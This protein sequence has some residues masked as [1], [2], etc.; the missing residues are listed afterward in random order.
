M[1]NWLLRT[2]KQWPTVRWAR[3][4]N[5]QVSGAILIVG[6]ALWRGIFSDGLCHLPIAVKATNFEDRTWCFEFWFNRYQ[7]LLGGIA[8]LFAAFLAYKAVQRQIRSGLVSELKRDLSVL[9]AMM[10]AL[11]WSTNLSLALDQT[12]AEFYLDLNGGDC[13]EHAAQVVGRLKIIEEA[14]DR[15]FTLGLQTTHDQ[16]LSQ[17][18]RELRYVSSHALQTARHFWREIAQSC[19]P[20]YEQ[21]YFVG[22]PKSVIDNH[23]SALADAFFDLDLKER[24]TSDC[25]TAEISRMESYVLAETKRSF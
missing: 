24:I 8:T 21:V 5:W 16:V 20:E 9:R 18:L 10:D 7:G 12:D 14:R 19:K 3:V 11:S 17:A 6:V 15:F 4:G 2:Y 13:R 22:E 23:R 25:L 1:L